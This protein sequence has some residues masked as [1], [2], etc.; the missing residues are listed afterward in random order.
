MDVISRQGALSN[1]QLSFTGGNK[2]TRYAVVSNYLD[3]KGGYHQY[4]VQTLRFPA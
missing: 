2:T 4:V 3:N 1:H